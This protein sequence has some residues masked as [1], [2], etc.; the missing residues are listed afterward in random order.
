SFEKMGQLVPFVAANLQSKTV[1]PI[2]RS[3]IKNVRGIKVGITG[4]SDEQAL[5]QAGLVG[6]DN[7][8]TAT[9]P[10]KAAKEVVAELKEQGVDFILMLANLSDSQLYQ[11]RDQVAGV[12]VVV[13]QFSNN[14][15]G[16]RE[17]EIE[18]RDA[19]R[20]RQAR[21]QLLTLS[22]PE[23][24]GFLEASFDETSKALERILH[25]T[26]PLSDDLPFDEK[27]RLKISTL[28][29]SYFTARSTTLM[30]DIRRITSNNPLYKEE[31]G[32][33]PSGM[34]PKIWS[35][36]V[37]NVLRQ[38]AGADIGIARQVPNG[39]S[40][41]GEIPRFFVERWLDVND[42]V[43]LCE[44][45]GADLKKLAS[46]DKGKILTFTGFDKE[47]NLVA[48][49]PLEEKQCYRVATT[50][51]IRHLFS[52]TFE[53]KAIQDR[54]KPQRPLQPGGDRLLLKDL[55]LGNLVELAKAHPDFDGPY[56]AELDALLDTKK[57][58]MTPQLA[59]KLD[60]IALLF[61]NNQVRT[62]GDY[63]QVRNSRVNNPGSDSLGGKLRFS[64]EYD[65]ESVAWENKIKS[66]FTQNV[67]HPLGK[68]EVKQESD[69]DINLQSE[70]RLKFVKLD[71]PKASMELVP[72]VNAT[73]DTE[74][75]PTTDA[76]TGKLN[77]RQSELN[78]IGGLVLYPGGEWKEVRLGGLLS[79]D[80][81]ANKGGFKPGFQLA[82]S[83][84]RRFNDVLLNL[85]MDTKQIF[86]TLDDTPEEL[87]LTSNWVGTVSV[88][89]WGGFNLNFTTD[90]FFFNGKMAT[91]QA[92]GTNLKTLVGL[93]Y[94][95]Q[96]RTKL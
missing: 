68:P 67:M 88:P 49:R 61:N 13:G 45:S 21:A 87:G 59:L 80:F 1:R 65:T 12:G 36:L 10:I 96:W 9:E 38:S 17:E 22:G 81:A 53:G 46:L 63:G 62:Q 37:S 69:D 24:I 71:M 58:V 5:T 76:T 55:V 91:N 16:L 57:Q 56:L 23:K 64:L 14:D 25:S 48:G 26:M 84:E 93:S 20:M 2:L 28:S 66:A 52:A 7:D 95:T 41:I 73:Y 90:A 50:D 33:Y 74:W 54:F 83:F 79:H 42:R 47:K 31:D 11:L 29:D 6:G 86:R 39:G 89:L 85:T 30:P 4:V 70:F 78:G 92:I 19:E 8:W 43:I 82:A 15:K 75:T 34:R 72:F 60:E 32:T 94:R 77:R 3:V 40:T 44:L 18:I 35:G 27:L 51:V